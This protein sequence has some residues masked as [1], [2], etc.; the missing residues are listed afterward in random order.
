MEKQP[1]KRVAKKKKN[2]IVNPNAY[3]ED[4]CVRLL[5]LVSEYAHIV[6]SG[7][8]NGATN[9]EKTAAWASIAMRYN[10]TGPTSGVSICVCFVLF[11]LV[12]CCLFVCIC[13]CLYL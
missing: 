12:I 4:E 9:H 2:E 8:T 5:T 10:A 11:C 13:Y 1:K 6:D 7:Q 3:T